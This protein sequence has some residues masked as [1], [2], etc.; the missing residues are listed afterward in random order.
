MCGSENK[1]SPTIVEGTEL[2]VCKDCGKFGKI[3]KKPIQVNRYARDRF[4]E[5]IIEEIS[6]DYSEKIKKAREKFGLKQ[7]ELAKKLAERESIIHKMESGHFKPGLALARKLESFLKIKI[8]EKIEIKKEKY[9]SS[10]TEART[11][12]DII[13]F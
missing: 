13:K 1:L 2:N 5:E 6:S 7:E 8:I 4:K 3:L 10:E 11:I 9:S 12:G